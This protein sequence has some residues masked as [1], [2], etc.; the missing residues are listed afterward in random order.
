MAAQTHLAPPDTRVAASH[1]TRASWFCTQAVEPTVK[2][3][4]EDKGIMAFAPVAAVALAC[5][6][7]V[8]LLP[9]LFGSNPDQV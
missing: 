3:D 4:K 1:A 9:L 6:A 7:C 8:P 2:V 5:I